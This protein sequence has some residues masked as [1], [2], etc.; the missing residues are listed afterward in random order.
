MG[1]SIVCCRQTADCL[2]V[3]SEV[4]TVDSHL[5]GLISHAE[6]PGE[7]NADHSDDIHG[8]YDGDNT[9]NFI[10]Q[11]VRQQEKARLKLLVRNFTSTAIRGVACSIIDLATGRIDLAEYTIDRLL[12]TLTMRFIDNRGLPEKKLEIQ[13]ITEVLHGQD[14]PVS[15]KLPE[16]VTEAQRARLLIVRYLNATGA[17]NELAFLEADTLG[18]ENFLT[19]MNILRLYSEVSQ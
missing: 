5:G 12:K 4:A 18:S 16:T 14:L 1:A 19:C 9:K 11:D 17:D 13:R 7:F 6:R 2:N 3:G 8:H 10:S 15:V